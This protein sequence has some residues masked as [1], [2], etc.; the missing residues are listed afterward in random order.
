MLVNEILYYKSRE[1][2]CAYDGSTPVSISAA[3]GGERYEKVRAGALGAK[4]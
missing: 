3:L 2:V 1:D 4:Y